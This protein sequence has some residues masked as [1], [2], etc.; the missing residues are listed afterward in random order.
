M[1][2]GPAGW[3]RTPCEPHRKAGT[4]R[5]EARKGGSVGEFEFDVE[6][7]GPFDA[8]R[9]GAHGLDG[10]DGLQDGVVHGG[11]AGGLDDLAVADASVLLDRDLHGGDESG[12]VLQ[13]F[14]LLPGGVEAV[15]DVVGVG[16]EGLRGGIVRDGGGGADLGAF[17]DE[18]GDFLVGEDGALGLRSGAADDAVGLA[19]DGMGLATFPL[20]ITRDGVLGYDT[21]FSSS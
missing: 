17:L 3:A 19:D 10:A 15:A 7:D 2:P 4:A 8:G 6:R 20:P 1:E 11:I 12:E 18:V 16:A 9:E 21:H 5:P 14:G 13:G